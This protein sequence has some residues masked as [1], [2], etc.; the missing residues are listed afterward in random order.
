MGGEE[1][2]ERRLCVESKCV[3]VDIDCVQI[4]KVENRGE[5]MGKG[6]GDFR[7]EA[8]GEDVGEVGNLE[9]LL[10]QAAFFASSRFLLTLRFFFVARTSPRTLQASIPKLLP[11]RR[12]SSTSLVRRSAM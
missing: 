2:N 6:V 9:G 12:T 5:K 3:V 4:W 7:E 8:S 10:V 11:K 1:G